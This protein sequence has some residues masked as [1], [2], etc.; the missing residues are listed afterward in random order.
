MKTAFAVKSDHIA[1]TL[2]NTES[3]LLAADDRETVIP[4]PA[5]CNMLRLLQQHGAEQL[6]CNRIGNCMIELFRQHNI[7]VIAGV[8]GDLESVTGKFRQGTLTPGS[9]FT[10]TEN[11][12]ICG[13][14]P[15]NY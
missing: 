9:G 12:Q 5:K 4:C 10:C 3:F 6:I 15:G 8:S 11:A 1:D 7:K 14:C 2:G 13:D